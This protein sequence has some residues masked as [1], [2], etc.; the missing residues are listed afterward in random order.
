VGIEHA[1]LQYNSA[2]G[3]E[4]LVNFRIGKLVPNAWDGFQEMWIMTD[5][6]IDTLFAYNPIGL[7]GGT[8]LGEEGAGV[9]LPAGARA[10]EV[11]GVAA[12]RFFYTI[13][14]AS[15]I[16]SGGPN[17]SFGSNSKKD[18]YARVDY[19]FGGLGLD[20]DATG[21]KLPPENWRETSF[22]IGV[23]GYTG[24]GR[25]VNF[26]LTDESGAE[27]NMQD[28]R[29]NRVGAYGSLLLGDLN[30]FGVALHGTDKLELL[31]AASGAE[32][33]T[34]KRSYDTW[35]LQADYVVVPPFQVS[36]RYENLR[37]A[38]SAAPLTRTLNANLSFLAAANIKLMVEYHRDLHDSL[39]YTIAGV[40]RAAF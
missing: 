2:F 38:D 14:V 16:G 20:G 30:L 3:P 4:H 13:G 25:D 1:V 34:T 7:R 40:L 8:G 33:S 18:L 32:I 36:L 28:L 19:K 37:P 5:N 35:F 27:F 23:L 31:D 39:N 17:G 21:V 11:Y 6:G 24:N 10:I 15:P 26:P 22:R 9:S 12:H 29:Y